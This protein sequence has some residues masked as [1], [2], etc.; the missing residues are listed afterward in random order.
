MLLLDQTAA[1]TAI[2]VITEAQILSLEALAKGSTW[3]SMVTRMLR[4]ASEIPRAPKKKATALEPKTTKARA[5]TKR[6]PKTPSRSLF[7]KETSSTTSRSH[8]AV[9]TRRVHTAWAH[10]REPLRWPHHLPRSSQQTKRKARKSPLFAGDGHGHS[11]HFFQPRV[12]CECRASRTG[13]VC[14]NA[15][16]LYNKSHQVFFADGSLNLAL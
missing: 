5:S 3:P 13:L 2:A 10:E 7:A 12:T 1:T 4:R 14:T 11:N 8:F 16:S 15:Q 6:H 9:L